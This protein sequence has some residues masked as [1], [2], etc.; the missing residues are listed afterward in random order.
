MGN[1][2]YH[3]ATLTA[4]LFLS[5]SKVKDGCTE[6]G[7]MSEITRTVDLFYQ[8]QAEDRLD[9]ELIHDPSRKGEIVLKGYANL[10]DGVSLEVNNGRLILSDANRCKWL[11]E[12]DNRVLC[13]VYIDSLSEIHSID[14]ASFFSLDTLPLTRLYFKHVSTADQDLILD[15]GTLIF[16]HSESGQVNLSG[17]CDVLVATMYETGKLQAEDM[18]A[19]FVFVYHY[20]LNHASVSPLSQLDC[21]IENS[22]SVYYHLKPQNG[23][24]VTGRGSGTVERVF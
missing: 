1:R 15:I 16:D 22:G 11:R 3:I 2:L 6:K 8:I 17:S 23:P 21:L 4:L 9:V 20:G 7:A 13:Q 19:D 5:C 18:P 24:N 10:L 14:D 12:L